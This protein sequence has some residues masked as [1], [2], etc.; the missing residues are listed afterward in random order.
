MTLMTGPEPRLRL[1]VPTY[2]PEGK[3]WVEP[4]VPVEVRY[5]DGLRIVLGKEELDG[6][7]PDILIER[8]AGGWTIILHSEP[9]GDPKGYVYF[10]DDG[11]A[12]ITPEHPFGITVLPTD[13]HPPELGQPPRCDP[14]AQEQDED[15]SRPNEIPPLSYLEW[16]SLSAEHR[17]ILE[18]FA[19][20]VPSRL[21]PTFHM[22]AKLGAWASGVEDSW[23]GLLAIYRTAVSLVNEAI[24]EK[25]KSPN[26]E[27]PSLLELLRTA[28]DQI[29]VLWRGVVLS[30]QSRE[31]GGFIFG[32]FS[33]LATRILC[34]A[35]TLANEYHAAGGPDITKFLS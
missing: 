26:G 14:G 20:S 24:L 31:R 12:F 35:Q 16:D 25:S 21:P 10:L 22:G 7:A 11:R 5:E 28:D 29:L 30:R 32:R 33:R 4:Y 23:P 13:E 15:Q 18:K 27:A 9:G 8:R 3:E 19:A 6:E 34:L 2:Y 1:Q 17:S